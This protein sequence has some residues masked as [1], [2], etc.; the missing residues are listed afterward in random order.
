[1]NKFILFLLVFLSALL[2]FL[3]FISLPWR[4]Q[5][6]A[7]IMF[8]ISYLMDHFGY[9][10]YRDIFD[11]NMPGTYLAYSIIAKIFGYSDMGIRSADLLVL[12]IIMVINWY[13]MKKISARVA[14]MGSVLWGLAYLGIGPFISMQREY[15]LL[16]PIL[17]GLSIYSSEM[18]NTRLRNLLVGLCFGAAAAIKPHAAIGLPLLIFLDYLQAKKSWGKVSTHQGWNF[19]R[20]TV[21]PVGLGFVLPFAAMFLYF[22]STRSFS[23]F[24]EIATKYW[25]LYTHLDGAH[26]VRSGM[27]LAVNLV[28]NYVLLGG[29]SVWLAP[30]GLGSYLAVFHSALSEKQKQQVILLAGLT[31]CY[32]IYP[33]FAGQ[34]W[35]YH[36]LLFLFFAIQTSALCIIPWVGEAALSKR[37]I[38]IFLLLFAVLQA[39]P[40]DT[41][42]DYFT[43]V[44]MLPPKEGRVDEIVEF[45]RP[46]LQDGDTIQP[47]DWTGGAVHAMLILK[48]RIAT[49]FIY[50]FHFYH[51]VS[52]DYIEGLRK[53]FIN[54]M[55]LSPPR[56]IIRVEDK[57]EPWV[58]GQDTTREFKELQ[59]L[60]DRDYRVVDEG[61]GYLIYELF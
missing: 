8:Y 39:T 42:K 6:D 53:K 55:R 5:H 36:W 24:M 43:G 58:Q 20:D 30:A 11:M 57:D 28:K 22:W 9:V 23:E 40:Y 14:W 4:Y 10:P 54:E 12:A 47:L 21:L 33:V 50:N 34:F 48:A 38:T 18:G 61:N 15:L 17:A 51:H 13:W 25:P 49:P 19:I 27:N 46:R 31:I 26:R 37:L 29:F 7:P 2:V 32:S 52:S 1:M 41:Y 44:K 45:L 59:D 16:L 3:A 60:L 35:K 56:F